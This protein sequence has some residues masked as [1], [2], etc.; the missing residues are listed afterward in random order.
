MDDAWGL[1][2]IVFS[3]CT[4]WILLDM[5]C[6]CLISC[7]LYGC[8]MTHQRSSGHIWILNSIIDR[9]NNSYWCFLLL[10]SSGPS[11]VFHVLWCRLLVR[12]RTFGCHNSGIVTQTRL[13][14]RVIRY[15]KSRMPQFWMSTHLWD[16]RPLKR[17][18]LS[19][20]V[21]C[22]RCY[23][24]SIQ[25]KMWRRLY[26]CVGT[27]VTWFIPSVLTFFGNRGLFLSNLGWW[28]RLHPCTTIQY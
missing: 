4:I 28:L 25:D 9:R 14:M 21:K 10:N 16:L 22:Q 18:L 26:P 1:L 17:G 23:E 24:T 13:L 11:L 6:R 5:F 12:G 2:V 8:L 15:T 27:D 20:V 3:G 19:C 7:L